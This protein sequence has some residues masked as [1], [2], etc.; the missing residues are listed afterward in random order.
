MIILGWASTDKGADGW[1]VRWV[2]SEQGEVVSAGTL[3]RQHQE[4]RSSTCPS[5]PGSFGAEWNPKIMV[6]VPSPPTAI[7]LVGWPKV[8][9]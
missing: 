1:E 9:A 8:L 5:R 6:I 4:H 7:S 3:S 2:Q